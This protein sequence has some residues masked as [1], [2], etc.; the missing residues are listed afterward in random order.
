MASGIEELINSLYEMVQDAWIIPLSSDKC[1]VEKEKV[2]D[3]LD[4]IIAVLP[5]D[6]KMARD[7]VERRNDVISAGKRESEA[8][9]RQAEEQAR[10]MLSENEM[11]QEARRKANDI[12]TAARGRSKELRKAANDYCED[13]L[14]RTEEAVAKA[15]EEVRHSR[16]EFK[17]AAAKAAKMD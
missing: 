14:K 7:I 1:V 17:N 11:V 9:R 8:I 10:V 5:N 6:L 13:S 2:L 3:I 15:L 4:E 12:L 16:Q